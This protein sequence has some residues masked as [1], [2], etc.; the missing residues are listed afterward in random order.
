MHAFTP[1][2]HARCKPAKSFCS[3]VWNAQ[4]N[5]D[6]VL[7]TLQPCVFFL[8]L[9]LFEEIIFSVI[10]V[11]CVTKFDG[12][13]PNCCHLSQKV[14]SNCFCPSR[15]PRDEVVHQTRLLSICLAREDQEM[16]PWTY[17]GKSSK[18]EMPGSVRQWTSVA[19]VKKTSLHVDSSKTTDWL[20]LR[21]GYNVTSPARAIVQ[22]QRHCVFV[23]AVELCW[24]K[25]ISEHCNMVWVSVR[26]LCICDRRCSKLHSRWN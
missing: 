24:I 19:P 26:S 6:E 25:T 22:S 14:D 7:Q 5:I 20:A 11:E 15:F 16:Y 13:H 1:F 17:S 9:I 3:D 2:P 18:V 8:R 12:Y 23:D 4:L 10:F 21:A